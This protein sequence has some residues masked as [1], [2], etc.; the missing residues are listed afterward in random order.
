MLVRLSP[1]AT[2]LSPPTAPVWWAPPPTPPSCCIFSLHPPSDTLVRRV[3][4]ACL[5]ACLPVCLLSYR[6]PCPPF[7]ARYRGKSKLVE[8]HCAGPVKNIWEQN[9][10][11]V[12]RNSNSSRRGSSR[13]RNSSSSSLALW[14]RSDAPC[15]V[16][17]CACVYRS[18][19]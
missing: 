16:C 15:S 18:G 5:P 14:F 8:D 3:Y 11:K 6:L 12:G 9:R 19:E 7:L 17:L 1:I 4:F 10:A 13:S 2:T